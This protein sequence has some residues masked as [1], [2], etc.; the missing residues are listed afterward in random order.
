[1]PITPFLLMRQDGYSGQSTPSRSH[2]ASCV[3]VA[4]D[5]DEDFLR[6][7]IKQQQRAPVSAKSSNNDSLSRKNRLLAKAQSEWML[8]TLK[9]ESSSMGSPLT[10]SYGIPYSRNSAII[11]EKDLLLHGYTSASALRQM[12]ASRFVNIYWFLVFYFVLNYFIIDFQ[13]LLGTASAPSREGF[14][15]PGSERTTRA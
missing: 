5:S 14:R 11:D 1:M 8:S 15:G 6:T 4:G 2:A 3:T 13:R 10:Y 9:E 12:T 7:P